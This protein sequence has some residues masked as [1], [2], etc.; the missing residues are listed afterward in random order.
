[1]T[2]RTSERL[3]E[4]AAI[5]FHAHGFGAVSVDQVAQT[6]G[7]TK[8]TLYQHFRSKDEL[9]LECLRWRL[10]RRESALD[11]I[12]AQKKHCSHKI[13]A[14][15]DW[16]ASNAEKGAFHGCAFLKATTET[17]ELIPQVR[18]VSCEAKR[19][20]RH[21]MKTA[22]QADGLSN[23]KSLAEACALLLEGAQALSAIERNSQPFRTA[24]RHAAALLG[25]CPSTDA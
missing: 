7:V 2:R 14:I 1:M 24:R 13:L 16:I 15:F 21:R 19:L 17:A 5:L 22:A 10:A 11:E 3:I 6:A 20:L 9:L 18:E 12:L 4:S 8:M 25:D 23:A